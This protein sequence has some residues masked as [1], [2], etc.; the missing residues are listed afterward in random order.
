[1]QSTATISSVSSYAFPSDLYRIKVLQVQDSEADTFFLEEVPMEAGRSW[2]FD[3]TVDTTTLPDGYWLW[4][5]T[6]YFGRLHSSIK[7]YYDAYYT[8]VTTSTTDIPVPEWAREAFIY[9]IASYCLN[10]TLVTGHVCPCGLTSKTP[11]HWTTR[12]SRL[13]IT[14]GASIKGS[15]QSI[16][17]HISDML[18]DA[19]VAHLQTN[20]DT[21][22]TTRGM[23]L[24]EV[25]AGRL[26]DDPERPSDNI[27]VHI[28]CPVDPTWQ[29]APV[30]DRYIRFSNSLMGWERGHMSP[31]GEVGGGSYWY[32]RLSVQISTYYTRDRKEQDPA[33]EY[34]NI[35]RGLVEK[36]CRTLAV[37]A[38]TDEFDEQR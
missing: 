31:L 22:Y 21:E 24:S 19:L 14:T 25:K 8:A 2:P 18:V 13:L 11:T 5:K 34:A 27:M 16:M 23:T 26:Q 7:L 1:M 4:N 3:G 33:R 15:W 6:I 9:W 28:G 30:G 29:D 20:L 17:A 35:T 36:Y 32:R 10:P 38:L 37:T 12:L